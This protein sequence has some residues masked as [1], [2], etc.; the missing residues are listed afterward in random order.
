MFVHLPVEGR[1][2][3]AAA[4]VFGNRGTAMLLEAAD[5]DDMEGLAP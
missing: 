3:T 5:D 2:G 4:L 1:G